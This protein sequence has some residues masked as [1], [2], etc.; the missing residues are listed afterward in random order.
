LSEFSDQNFFDTLPWGFSFFEIVFK[1]PAF[2]ASGADVL[3]KT[4]GEMRPQTLD[5]FY[6]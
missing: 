6:R 1:K 2:A 3:T 5:G 4:T